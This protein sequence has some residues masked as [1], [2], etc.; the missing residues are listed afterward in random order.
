MLILTGILGF[1]VIHFFDIVSI[2]RA[3]F[4]VKPLVWAGGFTILF[5]SLARMVLASEKLAL[6]HSVS[7]LGWVLLAVSVLMISLALFINLP[8]R[9]T[10]IE[11]GVG[12]KL[13]KTGLYALVRHPGVYWVALFFFSLFFIS[14]S[15]QMLIAAPIFAVLN[16]SLVVI[17]DIYFFPRMFEGY[18]D[19][20]K[21]TP[22]LIPNRRSFRA[23]IGSL[24][25]TRIA[26]SSRRV[27]NGKTG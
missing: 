2:K 4:G 20:Q 22:M 19:Y 11:E 18:K 12:D 9:K 15:V 16:T 26:Y 6:P 8:F 23:F 21:E 10:Y 14:G 7:V 17:Q 24:R 25:Q 13:V 3:P 1:I 5:Y 27:S